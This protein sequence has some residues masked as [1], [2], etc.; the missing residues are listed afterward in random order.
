MSGPDF[1]ALLTDDSSKET[2]IISFKLE[3]SPEHY[4]DGN[5]G[6]EDAWDGK[7]AAQAREAAMIHVFPEPEKAGS[8]CCYTISLFSSV[9]VP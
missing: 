3:L 6:L 7:N 2:W 4:W 1:K 9:V 5:T 8:M